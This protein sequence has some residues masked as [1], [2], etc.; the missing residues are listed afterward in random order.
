VDLSLRIDRAETG[1]A[2]APS[3]IHETMSVQISL[4]SP[5]EVDAEVLG[6]LQRAYDES[7]GGPRSGRR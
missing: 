6:W 4:T 2:A 7:P 3:K 5:D 1:R